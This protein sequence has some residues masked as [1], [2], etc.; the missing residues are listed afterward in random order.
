MKYF[1]IFMMILFV[2][3]D[4]GSKDAGA[5]KVDPTQSIKTKDSSNTPP[6][7]PKV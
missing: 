6:S 2:G 1:M 7:V 3:C 5:V 4:S